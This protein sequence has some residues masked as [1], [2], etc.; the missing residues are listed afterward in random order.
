VTAHHDRAVADPAGLVTDLVTEAGTGLG[1]EQVQAAV[2]S[3]SGGRAKSRRLALALADRPGVLSDGRS[4]AP[5]AVGDLLV[6]LHDAGARDISLPACAQCGRKIRV[7]HRSGQD[8]YCSS[9]ARTHDEPCAACGE[10][11]TVF[12]LDRAGRPRCARCTDVDD[13]DPVSVIHGLVAALDPGTGRE[14]I[15]AAVRRSAPQPAYQRRLAWALE[16]S[17][18]LLTGD[19]HLAPLRAIPRFTEMLCDAGIAGV[20]RPS[21]GH[22]GRTVRIDKPLDGVRACRR[23]HARSRAVPCGHCG[24]VRDP[25]TRDEQGRPV[26]ANCFT[27]AP[28]N[29]E[30]DPVDGG[31]EQ[32][33]VAVLGGGDAQPDG[34]VRLA[35]AGRAG[36][37]D[38]AGLGDEL[39]GSQA[40]DGVAAEPGLVV[41]AEVLDCLAGGEPG[42]PDAQLRA[43]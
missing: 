6:A 2:A 19:A 41:E 1:R 24:A 27:A 40:G 26:C 31:G 11:R 22:C 7:F 17:P 39:G 18:A 8:W 38:V 4:P 35:G 33:P 23:C 43:G 32:D 10:N 16:A 21:C 36:Q 15:A 5:R 9:C 12:S 20:V 13:R 42:R 3:V 30:G 34:Q 14:T 37:H 25:V 29:L 28:E